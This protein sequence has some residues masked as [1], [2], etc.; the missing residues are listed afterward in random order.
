MDKEIITLSDIEAEKYKFPRHKNLIL[1]R[2]HGYLKNI[3][4]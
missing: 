3:G 4:V 2:R 1:F